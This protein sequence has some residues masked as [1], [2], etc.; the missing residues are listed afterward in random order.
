MLAT[1]YVDHNALPDQESGLEGYKGIVATLRSA[2]PDYTIT[3]ED[4]VAE[5][6][7]VVTRW[8]ARGIH[9]GPY[10][11]VAPTGREIWLFG[12]HIHRLERGRIVEL[13]EHFDLYGLMQQ[14]GVI[15]SADP[16]EP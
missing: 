5:G 3:I 9:R 13:W 10:V 4:Q 14:L 8:R 1:D 16:G 11:G 7:K 6:D 12:I 2:F 15:A